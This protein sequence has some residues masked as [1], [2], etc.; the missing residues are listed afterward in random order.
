MNAPFFNAML[1]EVGS[2]ALWR[3]NPVLCVDRLL[4]R[5]NQSDASWAVRSG[6]LRQILAALSQQNIPLRRCPADS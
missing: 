4:V 1:A 2:D 5:W 3:T 6:R